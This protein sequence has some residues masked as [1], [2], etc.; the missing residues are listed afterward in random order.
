M[1]LSYHMLTCLIALQ[2]VNVAKSIRDDERGGKAHIIVVGE[3]LLL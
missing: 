1:F 2:G 3:L